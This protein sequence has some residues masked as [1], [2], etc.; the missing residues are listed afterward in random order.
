MMFRG[1]GIERRPPEPEP[2][3]LPASAPAAAWGAWP[4]CGF[5]DRS[6]API[7]MAETG[8]W[9]RLDGPG[10]YETAAAGVLRPARSGTVTVPATVPTAA[11]HPTKRRNLMG[12]SLPATPQG[13]GAAGSRPLT[14]N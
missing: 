10:L 5:T 1:S 14:R 2:P 3:L 8:A 13:A 12:A 9:K 11:A 7:P 6:M 4:P